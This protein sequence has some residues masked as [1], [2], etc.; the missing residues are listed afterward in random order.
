M[1][2][3]FTIERYHESTRYFSKVTSK[4]EYISVEVVME[5][6]KMTVNVMR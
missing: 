6:S 4:Y 2:L 5:T 3:I 1:S